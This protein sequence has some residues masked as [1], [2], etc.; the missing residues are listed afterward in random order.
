MITVI[1]SAIIEPNWL[2]VDGW[3]DYRVAYRGL[4]ASVSAFYK[5]V[6]STGRCGESALCI[7]IKRVS[8]ASWVD[9]AISRAPKASRS[10]SHVTDVEWAIPW[11]DLR[12]RPLFYFT[13]RTHEFRVLL[14]YIC[15]V[16]RN[17]DA[18]HLAPLFSLNAE[19]FLRPIRFCAHIVASCPSSFIIFLRVY[20][21]KKCC[22]NFILSLYFSA[23]RLY[24]KCSHFAN[25]PFYC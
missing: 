17:Y 20:C 6:K 19:S 18:P 8:T 23:S 5:R 21:V 12:G 24:S 22:G 3:V 14:L 1:K 9:R 15:S 11:K 7:S 25:F 16:I 10:S 13:A 2:R 4:G